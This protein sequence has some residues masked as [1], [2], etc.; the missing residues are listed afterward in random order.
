MTTPPKI[1]LIHGSGLRNAGDDGQA[2]AAKN[3][4]ERLIPGCQIVLGQMYEADNGYLWSDGLQVPTIH[5]YLSAPLARGIQIILAIV[6]RVSIHLSAYVFHLTTMTRILALLGGAFICG[7]IGRIP[8][9]VSHRCR[10]VLE[11]MVSID[12]V[13][14]SGGGN[15][16]DIWLR[17]EL[18]PR[19]VTYRVAA[20]LGKP[21][22]LSG[23]GIG[24]LTSRI[25]K[26]ILKWGLKYVGY[27]GCRDRSESEDLLCSLGIPKDKVASL[28]DDATDLQIIGKDE[29]DHIL[30][31]ESVPQDD[32]R[33]IAFHVRLHNFTKDFRAELI[34][35]LARL[36]DDLIERLN[37]KIL[38]I[39][40]SQYSTKHYDEDIGDAFEVFSKMQRRNNVYF[41]NR[42]LY[43]PQEI[44]GII[45]TCNLL[46]G[47]SYHSWVF[48]MS[49]RIPCFGLFYGEYFRHKSSGL[50]GWYGKKDWVLNVENFSTSI[51]SIAEKMG[52]ALQNADQISHTLAPTTDQLFKNIEKPALRLKEYIWQK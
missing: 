44:K 23:Q 37:V 36:C 50:F 38:F 42:R 4:L 45:S 2:M 35:V 5:M 41:I 33:M 47:F 52:V 8:F 27:I 31:L 11:V 21:V 30:I 34:P 14:S 1:L 26:T 18:L 24:P 3:R 15:L 7:R 51:T 9:F 40:I 19:A 48:A 10:E 22:V 28:G 43:L 25:G 49:C 17:Q 39:P 20:L 16:N 46:V 32:R 29:I 13:Y 12:G 6:K